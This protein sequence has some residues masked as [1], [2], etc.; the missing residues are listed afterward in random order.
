MQGNTIVGER[1]RKKESEL[2]DST[3][4][5]NTVHKITRLV[6]KGAQ[7]HSEEKAVTNLFILTR[8]R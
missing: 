5:R 3:K 6:D 7:K 1:E 8:E 2:M 4:E